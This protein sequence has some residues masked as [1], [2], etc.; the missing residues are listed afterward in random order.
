MLIAVTKISVSYFAFE[1]GGSVQMDC[2]EEATT[3]LQCRIEPDK[4]V[5]RLVS[6]SVVLLGLSGKG[7][8]YTCM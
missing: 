4:R 8:S 6:V 1:S 2:S 3:Q 7:R 5:L